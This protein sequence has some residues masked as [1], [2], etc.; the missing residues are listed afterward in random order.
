M[1]KDYY[2][3]I[4]N[5]LIDNKINKKVKEYSKNKGELDRY[6]EVGRLL[7]EAQGGED[8][9]KYGNKLIKEYSKRLTEELGPG[10]GWRNLYNMRNFYL[11]LMDN[12]ILQSLPAKLNWSQICEIL[13]IENIDKAN[14]YIKIASEQDLPYRKLRERIKSKE[15]ERLPKITK[16]KLINNEKL[17][18]VEIMPNPIIIP[19]TEN[20]DKNSIKEKILKKLILEDL[21]NFLRQLGSYYTYVGNEYQIRLEDR[22]YYIDILLFNVE[23]NCYI[24]IELKTIELKKE[25]I[26]QVKFYMEYIDRNIKKVYQNKTIGIILCQKENKLVLEYTSD[27][28]IYSREYKLV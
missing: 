3:E 26:G 23:F 25:D 13:P 4:K 27:D 11:L 14:Y 6:Y 7:I 28:R 20:I 12:E 9:A 22:Y 10:Y 5:I 1:I 24:V 16:E 19:N 2:T 18:M 17:E 8:K 21:D 15:Y